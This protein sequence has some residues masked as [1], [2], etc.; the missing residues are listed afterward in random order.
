MKEK[1]KEGYIESEKKPKRKKAKKSNMRDMQKFYKRNYYFFELSFT[2]VA[3]PTLVISLA[4]V[5][6]LLFYTFS[7]QFVTWPLIITASLI[8]FFQI[9]A[10]QHYVRRFHLEPHNMTIGQYLR[11]LF[12]RRSHREIDQKNLSSKEH[13]EWYDH[14]PV[15]TR[16]A[17]VAN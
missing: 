4:S 14:P 6:L 17:A 10:I 9:I 5:P 16:K 3:V 13:I 11:Y 12:D 1:I 15:R 7:K 2:F 8:V